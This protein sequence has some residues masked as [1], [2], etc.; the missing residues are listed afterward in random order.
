MIGGEKNRILAQIPNWNAKLI[1]YLIVGDL[2]ILEKNE[3]I[4]VLGGNLGEI[5]IKIKD[6][7]QFRLHIKVLSHSIST[8]QLK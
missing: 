6:Q 5:V 3:E 1:W 8:N 2:E 4:K 7:D